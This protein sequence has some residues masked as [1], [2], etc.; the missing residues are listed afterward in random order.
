MG[1]SYLR[2]G[3]NYR[4]RNYCLNLTDGAD[5]LSWNVCSKLSNC[6]T[7]HRRKTESHL[8]VCS[9]NSYIIMHKRKH[10]FSRSGRV[11]RL[12]VLNGHAA[13]D[14]SHVVSTEH[15]AHL[16]LE[17][18]HL[19]SSPQYHAVPVPSFQRTRFNQNRKCL[20]CNARQYHSVGS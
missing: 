3:S 9:L 6:A 13:E 1:C 10:R 7:Q 8:R 11:S 12:A 5:R 19:I 16:S 17:L 15:H 20:P 4:S 14:S 18:I 2:F